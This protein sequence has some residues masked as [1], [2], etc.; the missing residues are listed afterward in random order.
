M[1]TQQNPASKSQDP[2]RDYLIEISRFPLLTDGEEIT[3]G[4]RVQ[5]MIALLTEKEQLELHFGFEPNLKQ[6]AE[7]VQMSEAELNRAVQQGRRAKKKMI[8]ANLRLVV[9]IAKKY[10]GRNLELL[11]LIQEGTI[12]LNRA[13]EKFDP[14]KGYKFSTYGYWWI[15]QAIT[16]AIAND[17]RTIRFPVHVTEKLNKIEKTQ[18]KLSQKL[19]RTPTIEEIAESSEIGLEE[20][21]KCKSAN[22][23][24]LSLDLRIGDNKETELLSLI[25]DNSASPF[26][27]VEQDLLVQKVRSMLSELSPKEQEVISLRFGLIDGK[28][29]S[30]EKIARK[31]NL[32]R[33][34][35]RQ[36]ETLALGRLR[37]KYF[38]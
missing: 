3:C 36:L 20:I 14:T 34:R 17:S 28:E 30:R 24:L 26:D 23:R 11:D 18:Q 8:E 38:A 32:S 35:I 13:V 15:R 33:G 22:R 25:K 27:S 37:Q 10:Q 31:L 6:W 4:K 16:R 7:Q 12:G 29:L 5:R 2:I 1:I 21:R 9:H 19:G